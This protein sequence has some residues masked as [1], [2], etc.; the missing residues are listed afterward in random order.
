M[1]D[2]PTGVCI[3]NSTQGMEKKVYQTLLLIFLAVSFL[4][5]PEAVCKTP[6]KPAILL[7]EADRCRE[8]L[9]RSQK[10][11]KYRDNWLRCIERYKK[12]YTRYP[13]SDQ[14]PWAIYHSAG[15]YT[16]LHRYSGSAK[17]LHEAVSL[18][19]RIVDQYPSHLL[20]D[21]AQYRIG[22][23]F[24]KYKKDPSRAY[25]EFL[26]VEVKFP[27]GDMRPRAKKMLD[28]LAVVLS[29][30][31]GNEAKKVPAASRPGLVSVK[32]IRYWS[33][34]NY[35]RVVIDLDDRVKYE[36]HLIESDPT[37]GKPRR[38]YLDLKNAHVTSDIDRT[39]AI[40]D[41]LLK[42]ARAGQYTA[43]TVRVV[44]DMESIGEYKVFPLYD[45]S[46]IVI[47][48][49]RSERP[50]PED[51]QR[52]AQKERVPRKGIRKAKGPEGKVS[53]AQQLG[54]NVRRIVI[55]PGHGGRDPGCNARGGI[56]EKN[57]TLSIARLLA[58][59]LRKEIGC[60]VFLT[61]TKDIYLPLERRTAIANMRKADLFISLHVNAHRSRRVRGLETY[62]LN[63]ATDE[64]AVVVAARENATSEK[65]ISDLQ[66]ILS[67]LML[68]TKI[69]ESSRLAYKIQKGMVT[70]IG[71]K[72]GPVKDL[73]VKQAP[74]YVL[75]GAQMPAV[76]VEAGFL[77][78][79]TEKRR[80]LSKNY[81]KWLAE[82]I[83]RGI[84]DYIATIDQTYQGG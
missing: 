56:K 49:R 73:G 25:V 3:R 39:I 71:T 62:F 81:H 45:P 75:I 27:S 24:Y 13:K 52:L 1:R 77:T 2:C 55:D 18:Y 69:H 79:R 9:Y 19:K 17:Y 67:D 10:K 29:R 16:G 65:N 80:L 42:R 72:Y 78:N 74:F 84:K 4:A 6:N 31:E 23:I 54:L 58:K 48:V 57:I 63:I 68:N 11:K 34:P 14:A 30:R 22:E 82:G 46:R 36:C 53:L 44:L 66:S 51:I 5:G 35:T 7:K 50:A 15:L 43:D 21:D 76:L 38:F 83:A 40:K 47:D 12:V 61:R 60:E 33:T 59:E 41:D 32:D 20:A 37:L 28:R 70:D 64:G 8:A 26:K